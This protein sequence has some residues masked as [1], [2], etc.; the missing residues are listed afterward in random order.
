V[1]INNHEDEQLLEMVDDGHGFL[2]ITI[3]VVMV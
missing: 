3:P 2:Q 1:V